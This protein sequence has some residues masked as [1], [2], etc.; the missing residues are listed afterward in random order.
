MA[1][2]KPMVSAGLRISLLP[3]QASVLSVKRPCTR[4][5]HTREVTGG[6]QIAQ[7]FERRNPDYRRR[8]VDKGKHGGGE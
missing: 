3:A 1:S 7:K 4:A 5:N 2:E 8:I 6:C